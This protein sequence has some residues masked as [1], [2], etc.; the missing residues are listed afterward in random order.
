MVLL[1]LNIIILSISNFLSASQITM[2]APVESK[3]SQT[4]GD[5]DK[6]AESRPKVAEWRYGPAQLWYD[7]LGVSEDGSNF[8]YG[9]KLREEPRESQKEDTPIEMTETTHEVCNL[10]KCDIGM[11]FLAHP[12]LML[13]LMYHHFLKQGEDE[14]VDGSTEDKEREKQSLEDELFLMVT[15]LQ[16]EDDIIWNGEEVKHK[17]TKTQRASLAGWLPSSMTRNANAYNAQQGE[18]SGKKLFLKWVH[19]NFQSTI[20][21]NEEATCEIHFEWK[22]YNNMSTGLTRSNSQLVPPTPPPMLKASSISGSKRD[23]N[24]HDNQGDFVFLIKTQMKRIV[25]AFD[26]A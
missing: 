8:T 13:S 7:M 18:T 5:G 24:S 2:M 25:W 6:E 12:L 10:D 22:K 4:C 17:G 1:W 26:F 20:V 16:W 11:K 9:F 21:I 15:Q 3:F 14:A 19:F 23:K